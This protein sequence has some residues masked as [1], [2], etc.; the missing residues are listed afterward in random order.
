KLSLLDFIKNSLGDVGDKISDTIGS[1]GDALKTF[2]TGVN[3]L[4]LVAIASALL[5]LATAMDKLKDLNGVQIGKSLIA[6]GAGLGILVGGLKAISKLDLA[7]FSSIKSVTTLMGMAIAIKIMTSA[8]E[9][10]AGIDPERVGQGIGAMVALMAA[11]A[12]SMRIMNGTKVGVGS[13]QFLAFAVSVKMIASELEPIGK[14]DMAAIVKGLLGLGGVMAEMAIFMKVVSGSSFG[15]IK[16]TG[17]LITVAAIK[18]MGNELESLGRL[19]WEDISR[20]LAGLGEIGRA[21]V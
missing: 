1:V 21:H 8:M 2:T 4:S 18:L 9:E 13:L 14:M 10:V 16:A 20:G 11:M 19:S 17:L 3:V 5:I 12:T 7:G 6:I 15:P